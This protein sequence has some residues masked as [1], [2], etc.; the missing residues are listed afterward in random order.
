MLEKEKEMIRLKKEKER[1][2]T[3][4]LKRAQARKTIVTR[5]PDPNLISKLKKATTGIKSP[6]KK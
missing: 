4:D 1:K 6:K 5:E 2:E 3:E